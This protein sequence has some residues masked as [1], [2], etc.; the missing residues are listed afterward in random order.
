MMLLIF[1]LD[2]WKCAL[3]ISTVDRV[4][5]AVAITSL[6]KTPDIVLGVINVRGTILPAINLRSRF[7]L[8]PKAL[9]P[10]AQLIVAR[11]LKR[12][13]ALIVDSIE[14]VIECDEREIV[15]AD[16]ILPGMEHVQGILRLK[17]G[18]ILI[19]DLDSLLSLEEEI[20]MDKA[21]AG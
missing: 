16:S 19:Q 10:S 14:D 13:V 21:L 11:M 1:K 3:P 15:S 2:N 17:D 9:V 12:P 20:L 6:P 8:P 18:M 5:R 4:Y 7:H